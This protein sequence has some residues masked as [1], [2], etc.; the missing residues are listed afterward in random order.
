MKVLFVCHG[1]I[2]RSPTAEAVFAELVRR[3]GLSSQ[4]QVASAGVIGTH[5]GES[6]DIRSQE[7]A[8]RRG[9]DLSGIRA[10]RISRDLLAASDYILAMDRG[11]Q[12]AI[13][14]VCPVELRSRIQL[15]LDYAGEQPIREVPDPYYGDEAGFE[16]VL[17]L[18][19]K[20]AQGLCRHI[21]RRGIS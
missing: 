7:H 4:V 15:F 21:Q 19:E 13:A 16:Q 14:R 17:D 3:E 5:V 10:Q 8:R 2:C 9:Y 20:A 11:N 12:E 6:P 18:A 1:N